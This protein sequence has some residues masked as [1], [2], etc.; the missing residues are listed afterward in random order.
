MPSEQP[1]PERAAEWAR[2]LDAMEQ[3]L[4][5]IRA[6]LFGRAPMPEPYC[7]AV[8]STPIPDA[9][10]P[11]ARVL[12][13]GQEDIEIAL[14]ERVGILGAALH[15]DAEGARAEICCYVDRIA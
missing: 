9:L 10:V 11:R 3:H 2:A 6:S 4:E 5:E 13:V 14:R 1:P 7:V 8:P 15:R 12:V